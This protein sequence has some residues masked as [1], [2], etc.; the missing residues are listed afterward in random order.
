[1]IK[2]VSISLSK[3]SSIIIL[4]SI[5]LLGF[6]PVVA[7]TSG[8]DS[9]ASQLKSLRSDVGIH[10]LTSNL[11]WLSDFTY[12][13]EDTLQNDGSSELEFV[14]RNVRTMSPRMAVGFQILTSFFVDDSGDGSSFGIGSWGLGP[15]LRGY[16]F[17]TER[18]QPY[19]QA[20]ALFGKNLA[21]GEL[22]NTQS[23]GNGFR[24]RLGLRG[25]AAFR[26]N[27]TVGLFTE[28]GYDWESSELFKADA[29]ALQFNI[30][31][32]VYLFN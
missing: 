30:G 26:I 4:F 13:G 27:N 15:V 12:M 31:F 29:R 3:I 22:A 23:G 20:N 32:D 17:K 9:Q 6:K 28:I 14:Y 11:H 24:V 1:M 16:P 18:F 25:G 2:E 10:G 8:S 7:Q 5:L 21:V 19:V